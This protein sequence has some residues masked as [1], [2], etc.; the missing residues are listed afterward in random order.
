MSKVQK[1]KPT[2]RRLKR[3]RRVS[4]RFMSR[5]EFAD[6][7]G[8][9]VETIKRREKEAPGWPVPVK[10]SRKIVMYDRGDI[11]RFLQEAK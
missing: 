11:E 5:Y 3:V 10:I 9:H 4:Q 1:L 7:I 6:L 2:A 8:V